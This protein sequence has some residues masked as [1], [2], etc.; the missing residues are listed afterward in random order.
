MEGQ[1]KA[2]PV[3]LQLE[4]CYTQLEL[5]LEP[6][7]TD[8]H[9]S[10]TT[11]KPDSTRAKHHSGNTNRPSN[12]GIKQGLLLMNEVEVDDKN[13]GNNVEKYDDN[14]GHDNGH[15]SDYD[16][17]RKTNILI[18]N[19]VSAAIKFQWHDQAVSKYSKANT[20]HAMDHANVMNMIRGHATVRG[21][22]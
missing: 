4:P 7:C 16:S 1:H 15:D 8:H 17:D 21:H 6:C 10:A 13:D 18:D 20:H 3:A 5:Q 22:S 2:Q 14:N 9:A 11:D 19:L 12:L